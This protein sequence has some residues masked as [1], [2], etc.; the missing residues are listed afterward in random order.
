MIQCNLICCAWKYWPLYAEIIFKKLQ[1][2]IVSVK[3]YS[4]SNI[5]FWI[6]PFNYP[7]VMIT[8]TYATG[9]EK[10]RYFHSWRLHS[11]HT[12]HLILYQQI[13]QNLQGIFAYMYGLWRLAL[14][15]GFKEIL[16]FWKFTTKEFSV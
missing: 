1:E 2:V 11:S 4:V 12:S 10:Y 6:I 9:G 8:K 3:L 16:R 14:K 5:S 7:L 15:P 13:Q